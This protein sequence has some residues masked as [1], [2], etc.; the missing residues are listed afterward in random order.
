ME[1]PTA[2]NSARTN[3]SPPARCET[4]QLAACHF[5]QLIKHFSGG[6]FG[7][8]SARCVGGVISSEHK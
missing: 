4:L 3:G 5:V 2:Q 6:L 1:S 8:L 7:A